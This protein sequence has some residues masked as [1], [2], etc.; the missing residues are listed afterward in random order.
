MCDQTR[1]T[2]RLNSLGLALCTRDRSHTI[3][4]SMFYPRRSHTLDVFRYIAHVRFIVYFM[5]RLH[6]MFPVFPVFTF[7]H[8]CS[9]FL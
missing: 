8:S 1:V 3:S 5:F 9:H 4:C 7:Q 2:I 6:F